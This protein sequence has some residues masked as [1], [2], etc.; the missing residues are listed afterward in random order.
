MDAQPL[1]VGVMAHVMR[2]INQ[3]LAEFLVE[4]DE[5]AE[6]S[7][8]VEDALHQEAIKHY[9]RVRIHAGDKDHGAV[10]SNPLDEVITLPGSLSPE[11][12]KARIKAEVR[13]SWLM[14]SD[15]PD[16]LAC[17][18]LPCP[19]TSRQVRISTSRRIMRKPLFPE[20]SFRSIS[21]M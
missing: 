3:E 19:R 10:G 21:K 20:W 4:Q 5:E 18:L 16:A 1:D 14:T 11:P 6:Y 8:R 15:A 13:K 2:D 12:M 17:R 7:Q 9:A